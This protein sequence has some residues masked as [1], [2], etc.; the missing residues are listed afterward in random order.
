MFELTGNL[1][2]V[3]DKGLRKSVYVYVH[4]QICAWS[5]RMYM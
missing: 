4:T 5:R 3:H 2:G 1:I